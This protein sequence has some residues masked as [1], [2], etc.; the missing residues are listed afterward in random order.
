MLRPNVF[1]FSYLLALLSFTAIGQDL[2]QQLTDAVARSKPGKQR[3]HALTKLADYWSYHDTIKAFATLK[4]AEPLT[5]NDD[6]LLG[7]YLF[8]KAG[9]YF[10]NDNPKSQA[11]YLRADELLKKTESPEA[12]HYR[13]KLWHNYGSLEQYANDENGFLDITLQYCIPFAI[14]SGDDDLLM[15]YFIN[16]GIVFYNHKEYG[17]ALEYYEKAIALGH[18]TN[19]TTENLLWAYLNLLEAYYYLGDMEKAQHVLRKSEELLADLPDKKLSGVFYKNKAKLLSVAGQYDEALQSIE[20]GL[21]V[22]AQY[23]FNFDLAS[24]QYEKA[25]VLK[26]SGNW[27]AAKIELEALLENPYITSLNKSHLALLSE[28]AETEAQLGN[29]ERAYK[30]VRQHKVL[31]DSLGALNFKQQLAAKETQYRTKEKEQE[32]ILLESRNQFNQAIILGGVFMALLL[33]LWGLYAWNTR[34]KRHQKNK[35][36]QRQQQEIDISKALID[37]EEQERKRLAR[38]LHDGLMGQVT[39]IKMNVERLARN[40]RQTDLPEIVSGLE[41]VIIE[42]R[43]TAHNLEPVVLKNHG[44]EEA[45]Q[46]FCQS[47]ESSHTKIAFY[48]NNLTHVVSKNLTLSIYRIVQ[49]LITNAIRH[50]EASEIILQCA[51]ENNFL[52][53]EMEDNGKGFDPKTTPRNMGLNNLEARIKAI[54]GTISIHSGPNQGTCITIECQ[55]YSYDTNRYL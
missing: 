52:L 38:E 13:A 6:Y 11:L 10:G 19:K 14:K 12:Y 54:N 30:L 34:K 23:S 41:S 53:I 28:L 32:I 48:P 22:A 1:L 18:T 7:I 45:I 36:L 27:Q 3:F 20:D 26:S 29:F 8:Y 31:N 43:Q 39:G 9:I 2:E 37:G 49:E 5:K 35:I 4:E 51:I 24:L 50:A 17:K 21:Q 46:R 15:S 47:M 33:T 55:L 25:Q 44:L 40:S 16:V 42:L